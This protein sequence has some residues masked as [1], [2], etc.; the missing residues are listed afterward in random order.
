MQRLSWHIPANG[1]G[2]ANASCTLNASLEHPTPKLPKAASWCRQE[3]VRG[4]SDNPLCVCCVFVTY[5]WWRVLCHSDEVGT[6]LPP[7]LA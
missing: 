1:D 3:V 6:P 2:V 4:A 7:S 5:A